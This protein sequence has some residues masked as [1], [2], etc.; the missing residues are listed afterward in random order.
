[1]PR[2]KAINHGSSK[3]PLAD[4]QALRDR[5]QQSKIF[6]EFLNSGTPRKIGVCGCHTGAGATSTALGLAIMLQERTGEPVSL[7]EAN[8]RA[9]ALKNMFGNFSGATFADLAQ[10]KIE[11]PGQLTRLPG[12]HVSAIIAETDATPLILL[13]QAKS[14]IQALGSD[15]HH[16]IL[17]LPPMLEYPDVTILAPAIDGVFMVLKAEETRWEVAREARNQMESAD[18]KLL[19]AVLNTKPHYIPDWLYSLL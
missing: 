1:M 3:G 2:R 7:I 12:T 10:G 4:N 17:D 16:V 11:N 15:F 5:L 9:P 18:V 19:G 14:R 6:D 8:L 13:G